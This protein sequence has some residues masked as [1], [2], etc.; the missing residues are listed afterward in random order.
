MGVDTENSNNLVVKTNRLVEALQT[1]SLVETR[2]VQLAIIDA[3]ETGKGITERTPL[4]IHASRYANA[5]GLTLDAAY[6]AMLS[7]EKSLFDRQ[8]TY[9]KDGEKI[10]TRW[11]SQVKYVKGEPRIEI[12]F[13]PAVIDEITRLDGYQDALTSYAFEKTADLTSV[14]AVRLY[15][16]LI[17]WRSTGGKPP[18]F[19]LAVFREQMGIGV[20]EY[21]AMCDFKKAVLDL[22][23]NQL[24][25]SKSCDIMVSYAQKKT[26]KA[27]AGFEFRFEPKAAQKPKEPKAAPKKPK[28]AVAA[29]IAAFA[30]SERQILSALLRDFDFMT[31][32]YVRQM[33]NKW[34]L[35][36]IATMDRLREDMS[37]DNFALEKTD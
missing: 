4:S 3:R 30:G 2:L 18:M 8:F 15:E 29:N 14:Y 25:K 28:P 26:G 32:D 11:V 19:K 33:M 9:T 20:N 24:N 17:Q 1:L 10:R 31:E 21:K 27:I 16:L 35:D 36:A 23:V 5:L 34:K 12:M 13:T 7:A 6:L 37:P 22:A